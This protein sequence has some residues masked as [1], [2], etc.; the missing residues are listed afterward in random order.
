MS[1]QSQLSGGEAK[2]ELAPPLNTHRVLKITR[3]YRDEDTGAEYTRV[4]LVRKTMVI[5]AYV[6]IRTTKDDEFI[7]TAFALDENE[8][9]NLRKERRR[10]VEHFN[11][12]NY[13]NF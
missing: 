7:R 3:T 12:N 10:S 9:K 11:M 6:K 8:K 4:E 2:T 13:H 1:Q 5:D